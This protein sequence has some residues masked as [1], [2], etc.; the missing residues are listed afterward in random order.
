MNGDSAVLTALKTAAKATLPRAISTNN[1]EETSVGSVPSRAWP[2]DNEP[3][4]K[5]SLPVSHPAIDMGP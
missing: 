3:L 2:A 4:P 1:G 5:K